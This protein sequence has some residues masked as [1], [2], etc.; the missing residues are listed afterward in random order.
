MSRSIPYSH[1]ALAL[2]ACAVPGTALPAPVAAQE[3]P[4]VP[5][6]RQARKLP[7]QKLAGPRFGFTTFAGQVADQRDQAGLEPMM[8]Q[9]GWQWETQILS[10]T[11]G[12]QALM[13]WVLLVGGVEQDESNLSLGWLTGYRLPRVLEIGVSPNFSYNKDTKNITTS[14]VFAGG[15]TIP[16]GDLYLPINLAVRAACARPGSMRPSSVSLL[17]GPQPSPAA[18]R[19]PSAARSLHFPSVGG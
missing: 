8:T 13:E 11:G 18:P 14:T 2:L 3:P 10:L 16:F 6:E 19:V 1:R 12:H 9:L 15:A 17:R 5:A 7:R 4:V